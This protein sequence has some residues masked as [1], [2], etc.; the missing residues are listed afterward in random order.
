MAG[1]GRLPGPIDGVET[2]TA[3]VARHQAMAF[4][5]ALTI[6]RD[7]QLAQDAT[8]EAFIAAYFGLP[9]LAAP[10]TFTQWLR[11]IVRHQ[12]WRILRRRRVATV[13]LDAA[14]EIPS[15]TRGPEDATVEREGLQALLDTLD[16]LP[17][18]LRLPAILRYVGEHSQR[19]IATF[20]DLPVTT[21]NNR[22]HAARQLLKHRRGAMSDA[23]T[24][25][26]PLPDDFAANVGRL[27]RTRGALIEARFTPATLPPVLNT[28]ALDPGGPAASTASVIQHLPGGIARGI[29][30]GGVGT[31]PAVP[32]GAPVADTGR[33]SERTLTPRA[34]G[35][36][37]AALAAAT[38]P[39][40]FLETG[41]KAVDLLCPLPRD[42]AIA[43]LGDMGVG[44]AVLIAEMMGNVA[45]TAH[46][47]IIVTCVQPGA[48]VPFFRPHVQPSTG[49]VQNLTVAIDQ[50]ALLAADELGTT[51]AAHISLTRTLAALGFY[52]ALDPLRSDSRLLDPAIVG[53]EHCRVAR[54]ACAL[55]TAYPEAAHPT[56]RRPGSPEQ[57]AR[58]L[59]RFLSQ[60]FTIAEPFTM[61]PGER[62]PR[63]ETVRGCAAIMRGDHDDL[64]EAAFAQIGRIEQARDKARVLRAQG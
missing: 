28:L 10:D 13:T 16:T 33:A 26:H 19:E 11:G 51:F 55:L 41:I 57:R 60:P 47:L 62:V 38:P 8:Q 6:L 40:A 61:L 48:E 35:A 54:A 43:L 9:T 63:E 52:P 20:L 5:Y 15:R 53:A 4:G 56:D 25:R 64:P 18:T 36:A 27:I 59:R 23:H 12:C 2:F 17:E 21:V 46:R 14:H 37:I 49:T 3:L 1:E 32:D 34:L 45:G 50:A 7:V 29:I 42:G 31:D 58:R 30:D 24:V 22:L 44:K 39:P